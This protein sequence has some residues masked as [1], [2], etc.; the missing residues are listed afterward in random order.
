VDLVLPDTSG[1]RLIGFIRKQWPT[2][3]IVLMSGYMSQEAGEA[4]SVAM[5]GERTQYVTKPVEPSR[6]EVTIQ[7]LLDAA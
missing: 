5:F 2:M 1:L 6:L 4:L 3:P 7:H